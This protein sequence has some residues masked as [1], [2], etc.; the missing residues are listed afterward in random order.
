[1]T[2]EEKVYRV[3]DQLGVAF[4]KQH[5]PVYTVEEVEQC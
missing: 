2:N 4:G 1:M 5:P 3:L